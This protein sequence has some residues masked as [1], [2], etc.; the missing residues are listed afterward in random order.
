MTYW[1]GIDAPAVWEEVKQKHDFR[2]PHPLAFPKRREKSVRKMQVGD[3]IINYMKEKHV[4]FAVWEITKERFFDPQIYA[5]Q[6]FPECVEVKPIVLVEPD[7]GIP[8][9]E[10][11]NRLK[12][13]QK[14]PNKKN[15]GGIVRQSATVWDEQDGETILKALGHPPVDTELER[16]LRE[17]DTKHVEPT[18]RKQ[19]VDARLGQ[20]QFR[21]SVLANWGNRCAVTGSDVLSAVRA[22]HLK[23]WKRST[24]EERLS[25]NNGLPLLATFDALFDAG[26]ITFDEEGLMKLSSGLA[27]RDRKELDLIGVGNAQRLRRRPTD[28]EQNFLTYH[29]DHVFNQ[30]CRKEAHNG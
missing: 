1:L 28:K 16:D 23:P 9:D 22:S 5:G 10:I 8:F 24:D 6:E 25:S 7:E 4:F 15:W 17:I 19:L 13:F 3:R 14:I 18:V 12:R 30:R 11:K 26:L 27:A 2:S 20:G 21:S 29:R